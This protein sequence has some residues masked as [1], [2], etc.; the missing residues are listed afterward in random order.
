[1]GKRIIMTGG[2]G[3]V[4][5]HVIQYLLD[6]DFEILNLDLAPLAGE[7]GRRVHT[8][9][10]DLTNTGQVYSAVSSHFKLTEPFQEPLNVIPDAVIHFGGVARNMLVPDCE[11]YRVNTMGSYNVMEASCRLGVKK[12]ILASSVCTYGVTYAEGDV[13][14]ASFPIDE[15]TD[16]NPMDVYALSKICMESTARSFANRFKVDIYALRIGAVI[17][18]EEH[19]RSFHR[20]VNEPDRWKVHGWSYVDVRDLAQMCLRGIEVDGLGF[21]IFNAT[22]DTITNE[23]VTPDFLHAQCPTT[24]F[25]RDLE[26]HEA[27]MS[28]RKIKRC[29]GFR[30]EHDWKRIYRPSG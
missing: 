5:Q 25:T 30:E 18:P 21:Q 6:N 11:T 15:E 26:Q 12:I 28:N 2:S 29:L 27:P 10:V 20:Y 24:P 17:A 22:N 8:L 4:G 9:K 16:T 19:A 1:M 13:D 23:S 7:L 14:F 3:K